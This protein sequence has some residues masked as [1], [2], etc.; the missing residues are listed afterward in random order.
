MMVKLKLSWAI[1]ILTTAVLLLSAAA[2]GSLLIP[3]NDKAKENA[4]A[5]ENSPVIEDNWDLVRVDF[6]HYAKPPS[7]P[8]GPK[9]ESCY[10]LTGVKWKTFPVS[11]V[12]NPANPQ[13]L[14]E[15]FVTSAIA[16]GAEAW[17]AETSTELFN[18]AY[19]VNYSAQY[20]VQNFRN[21]IDFND[22]PDDNVIAV[23]TFWYTPVGKRLV[24]YDMRFNTRFVWGDAAV[25][26][27]TMDLQSIATHEKGHGVGLGDIYGATCSAVTMYGYSA[28]GETSKRT[29]EQPDVTGLQQM[30]GA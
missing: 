8:K 9:T 15:D 25:D 13:N 5:P 17:D 24:E 16:T 26:N 11:Y 23:T 28:Y 2:T 14:S 3:A 18:N 12:I 4:K 6:I 7:P 29:L 20:G 27:S 21:E 10:K 19:T 30:Y 22:Y 1:V